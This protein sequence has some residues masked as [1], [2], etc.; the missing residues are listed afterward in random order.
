MHFEEVLVVIA[1]CE[2][3]GLAA[4]WKGRVEFV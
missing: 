2:V 1:A 4:L 3:W